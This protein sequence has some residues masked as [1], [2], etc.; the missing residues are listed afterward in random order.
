MGYWLFLWLTDW[1]IDCLTDWLTDWLIV[2]LIDWLIDC[3]IDWLIDWL[4]DWLTDWLLYLL[5]DLQ[6]TFWFVSIVF[7]F[8]MIPLCHCTYAPSSKYLP[9]L[10]RGIVLVMHFLE[11]PLPKCFFKKLYVWI[12]YHIS[13]LLDCRFWLSKPSHQFWEHSLTQTNIQSL[14]CL[15]NIRQCFNWIQFFLRWFPT[16]W[17]LK[18]NNV[19]T[20]QT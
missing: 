6:L 3:L 19:I 9:V 4:T 1:L 7:F 13:F 14:E 5:I 2:G 10:I 15:C 12:I 11:N 17:C 20:D 16:K 18:L 8:C